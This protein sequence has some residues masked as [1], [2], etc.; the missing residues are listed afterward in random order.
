VGCIE[1]FRLLLALSAPQYVPGKASEEV[2]VYSSLDK[3]DIVIEEKDAKVA[4]QTDHRDAVEI[5]TDWD[6]SV[7]FALARIANPVRGKVA[8]RVRVVFM[9]SPPAAM[10]ELCRWA[11]AE[12]EIMADSNLL[13]PIPDPERAREVGVQALRSLGAKVLGI[14]PADDTAIAALQRYFQERMASAEEDDEIT[15][16]E[17]VLDLGA[18]VGEVIL[19]SFGGKWAAD[20]DWFS[21]IPFVHEQGGSLTNVFGKVEKYLEFGESEQPVLLLKLLRDSKLGDGPAM[22]SLRPHDWAG[23][24]HGLVLPLGLGPEVAENMPLVA[25]VRDMPNTV[26]TISKSTS[27]EELEKLRAE[28][29][30]NLARFEV[31]IAELEV[32]NGPVLVVHGGYYASEKLLDRTFLRSIHE[33]LAAGL[34]LASVPR[35]GQLWLTSG[36]STLE[37]IGA[38]MMIVQ[39]EH[40]DAVPNERISPIVFVVTDGSLSGIARATGPEEPPEEPK[41]RGLW[42]RVFGTD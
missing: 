19:R 29:D 14:L 10:V 5:E 2:Q 4:V 22:Y 38:F 24:E 8:D 16:W 11:G 17:A 7:L 30:E 13:P 26:K 9:Q 42:G 33:R 41:K 6:R 18:G 34:L 20:P 39:K 36:V 25:L 32:P 1:A 40:D 3:V 35:K 15:R 23:R 21:A 12:V 31:R 37:H 28:A 27:P